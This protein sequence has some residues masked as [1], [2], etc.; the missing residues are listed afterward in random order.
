VELR[1]RG[2]KRLVVKVV[3]KG[4]EVMDS[5]TQERIWKAALE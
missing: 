5:R 1:L 2:L 4:V 3:E